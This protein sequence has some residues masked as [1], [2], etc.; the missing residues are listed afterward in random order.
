M[1]ED[2]KVSIVILNYN[3]ARDT[4]ECIDSLSKIEYSD[5]NIIIVDNK[6][7][8]NSMEKLCQYINK[9]FDN[10]Q[11]IKN[12]SNTNQLINNTFITLIQSNLNGG[13]GYGNNIG[14]N[15][16][17]KNNA[18]YVMIL[19][20]DTE[21]KSNIL[22]QLVNKAENTKDIGILSCKTN[23]Y[24]NKNMI[25]FNGGS[26]NKC[27]GNITHF[28]FKEENIGQNNEDKEITFISGCMWF[29]PKKV[30]KEV[31]LINEDYFM[32]V[33]DV[34][35]CQ[36]VLEK[37]YKLF[38]LKDLLL[39]HKVGGSQNN[40]NF[41]NFTVYYKT[42]NSVLFFKRFIKKKHCRYLAISFFLIQYIIR[43]FKNKKLGSLKSL[44][45]GCYNAF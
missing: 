14:I 43:L 28:N 24:H 29:I 37:E 33:E 15:Y 26:F 36:R 35:Y 41:S 10:S 21:V 20:N 3:N 25:W 7:T 18:D 45:K 12:L 40:N 16:A 31:G 19:N 30:L 27:T 22:N 6:S 23:F 5:F 4:I 44:L 11:I 1:E 42:K 8:D 2:K 13:Y 32:Y 9:Q 17:L 38:V 34:E 39:F